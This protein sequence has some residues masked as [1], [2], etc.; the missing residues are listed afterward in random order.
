MLKMNTLWTTANKT[1]LGFLIIR[2]YNND[3]AFFQPFQL[4]CLTVKIYEAKFLDVAKI[5]S[6]LKFV[7]FNNVLKFNLN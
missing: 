3:W 4:F 7:F 2:S 6:H 1:K 5:Q